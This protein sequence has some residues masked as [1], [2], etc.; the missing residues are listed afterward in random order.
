M[1]AWRGMGDPLG[2]RPPLCEGWRGLALRHRTGV[3]RRPQPRPNISTPQSVKTTAMPSKGPLLIPWAYTL[4]RAQEVG[5]LRHSPR[6]G[7]PRP[8]DRDD[9]ADLA[10]TPQRSR[11]TE[12]VAKPYRR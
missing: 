8:R 5:F 11:S 6:P 2:W 4:M 3:K 7:P 9:S 12:Q 1:E 10:R